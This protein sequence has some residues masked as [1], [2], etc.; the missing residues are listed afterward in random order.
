MR[1]PLCEAAV[2]PRPQVHETPQT[3]RIAIIDQFSRDAHCVPKTTPARTVL[4]LAARYA[5]NAQSIAVTF[6]GAGNH[7]HVTTGQR[8]SRSPTPPHPHMILTTK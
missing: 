1:A 4:R 7:G 3:V 6:T 2:P 5:A 8:I